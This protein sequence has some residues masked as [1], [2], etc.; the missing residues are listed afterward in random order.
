MDGASADSTQGWPRAQGSH[1]V[2]PGP[3]PGGGPLGRASCLAGALGRDRAGVALLLGHSGV[4][5]PCLFMGTARG[6]CHLCNVQ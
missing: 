2:P 6:L 4:P 3:L 5:L 1:Q